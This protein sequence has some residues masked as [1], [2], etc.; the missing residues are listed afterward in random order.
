MI[1]PEKASEYLKM[2]T[3]NRTVNKNVVMHYAKIMTDGNWELTPEGISFDEYGR[4]L[5]GQ[6]RLEAILK[7]GVSVKMIVSRGFT[8]NAFPHINTG[9]SRTASDVLSI[10]GIENATTVASGIKKY[11]MLIQNKSTETNSRYETKLTNLDILK[12]YNSDYLFFAH[13]HNVADK[14]YRMLRLFKIS[15]Y[16]AVYCYLIKEK[17]HPEAAVIDFFEQLNT[18][19]QLNSINLLRQRI[20]VSKSS[21]NKVKP[22]VLFAMLIKCWNSYITKKDRKV[23]KFDA[24]VEPYPTFI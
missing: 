20:V 3:H 16:Y 22:S 9:K 7:S 24:N 6:H 4:L 10:E 18:Y 21:V 14:Y 8:K 15:D 2:N 1:T 11:Q 5:D 23:L 13:A 19:S 12:I 17:K